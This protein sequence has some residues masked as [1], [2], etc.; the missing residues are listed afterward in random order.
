MKEK[1]PLEPVA[2]PIKKRLIDE[3]LAMVKYLASEGKSIPKL[4]VKMLDD[5]LENPEE[6]NLSNDE[7]IILHNQLS[8]KIIPAKPKTIL[9]LYNESKV[10]KWYKFLGPVWLV[11]RLMMTTLICLMVFIG[12]SLSKDVNAASLAK[13]ILNSSGRELFLNLFF[14]LSA[15][16]LGGCFSAL[17]QVNNYINNATYDPK[18][19]SSY[20]IRLLLGIIAG[21]MLAVVLTESMESNLQSIKGLHL[22]IPLLAMIGGF[23]AALVYR[24][25]TRLVWAVESIF[26]GKQDD[27]INQ[28]VLNLQTLN[29]KENLSQ[30]QNYLKDLAKIKSDISSKKPLGDI[31]KS[32]DDIL[33]NLF[34]ES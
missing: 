21:L 17:F 34:N 1:I 24:I 2:H 20:W 27:L 22:T 6:M 18:F 28:K 29:E 23:S 30:K 15:A 14:I 11:R 8:Q 26:L 5:N 32:V 16:A 33:N 3:N 12:I 25:L 19:E 9:L 7:I 4:T 31:E 13:G 10:D